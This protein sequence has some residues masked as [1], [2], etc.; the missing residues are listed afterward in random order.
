[1]KNWAIAGAS[2]AAGLLGASFY[3]ARVAR[4]AEADVPMDGRIVEASP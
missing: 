3:S 2:L 4:K 1:M